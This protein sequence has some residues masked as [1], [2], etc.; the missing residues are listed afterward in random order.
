MS[1]SKTTREIAADITIAWIKAKSDVTVA[2]A[3]VTADRG[4]P[5]AEQV[6]D[7]FRT[8]YLAVNSPRE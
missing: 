3:G 4:L 5:T 2:G 6:A 8:V 7:Y 1:E